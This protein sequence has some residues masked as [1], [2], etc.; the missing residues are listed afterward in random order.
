MEDG[1]DRYAGLHAIEPWLLPDGGR[2]AVVRRP[3]GTQG[4]ADLRR[5]AAT[6][7]VAKGVSA[8]VAALVD[9]IRIAETSPRLGDR[10]DTVALRTTFERARSSGAA[11][12]RA[13]QEIIASWQ[14][15]RI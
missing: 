13:P 3:A 12:A 2:V 9:L 10:A 15:P 5:D 14:C 8:L 4:Y 11:D 1:D 6:I 7:A